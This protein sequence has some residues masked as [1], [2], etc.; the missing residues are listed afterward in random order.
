MT[1]N[2]SDCNYSLLLVNYNV[3]SSEK[4]VT[5][6]YTIVHEKSRIRETSVFS[7]RF[8]LVI[9]ALGDYQSRSD[10]IDISSCRYTL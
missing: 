6:F 1:M 9:K 3:T 7:I 4:G 8:V 5:F 10:R 2:Y